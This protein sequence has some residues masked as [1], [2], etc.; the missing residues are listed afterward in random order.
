MH[1]GLF[2]V[3]KHKRGRLL[4]RPRHGWEEHNKLDFEEVG[5]GHGLD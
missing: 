4:V 1:S 5:W 2:V 3:G